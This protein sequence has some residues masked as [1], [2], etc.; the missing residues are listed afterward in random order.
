MCGRVTQKYTWHEL[1]EFYRLIQ[2]A[3]NLEPRYNVAPDLIP[4]ASFL[5]SLDHAKRYIWRSGSQVQI[6]SLR[7]ALS[8]KS[9]P[10]SATG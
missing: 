2:P 8:L 10:H 1:V 6:L 7:P 4:F 5:V 9:P 3:R